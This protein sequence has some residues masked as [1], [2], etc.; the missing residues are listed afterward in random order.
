MTGFKDYLLIDV[1]EGAKGFFI[2]GDS[3]WTD[4]TYKGIF[5][6]VLPKGSKWGIVEKIE[7]KFSGHDLPAF[8]HYITPGAFIA[9]ATESGHSLVKSP[10]LKNPLFVK[11]KI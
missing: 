10:G 3:L 9:T 4:E 6:K 7:V 11:K 1:P 8:N 2:F 5:R